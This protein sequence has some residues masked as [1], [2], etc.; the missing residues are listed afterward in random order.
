MVLFS[1]QS[2]LTREVEECQSIFNLQ[3][4]YFHYPNSHEWGCFS[5]LTCT[6]YGVSS[7]WK[8]RVPPV[9]ALTVHVVEGWSW[10]CSLVTWGT[11]CPPPH[12]HTLHYRPLQCCGVWRVCVWFPA[13]SHAVQ[14]LRGEQV[15]W[16]LCDITNWGLEE[17]E[18]LREPTCL[19]L[20]YLMILHYFEL[21][22]VTLFRA[23]QSC[24]GKLVSNNLLYVKA[25]A[26][27]LNW[28]LKP[29]LE[30]L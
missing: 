12:R 20:F 18:T 11:P 19:K 1:L 27:R 24:F 2:F 14:L 17:Q 16:S 10:C 23:R 29:L 28:N 3:P 7:V 30:F 5:V 25:D 22:W 8:M 26:L 4:V 9:W 6:K 15:E 21:V 13:R